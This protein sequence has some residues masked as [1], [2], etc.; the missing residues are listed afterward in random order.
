MATITGAHHVAFTVRDIERSQAWY[1][2]VLGLQ[3]LLDRDD[4]TTRV[5]VMAHPSGWIIGLRQH[6]GQDN[7]GPFSEF[8]TGLD[9]LALTVGSKSELDEW[10]ATLTEHAV[11]F[12]P[13]KETPIGTV[14]AFRD[15]DN[16]ALELWLP[17][18]S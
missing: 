16:I 1:A 14:I 3:L 12:T 8:R 9:H 11:T 2:G 18:G 15:L 4:E 5:R 17:L 6:L 7:G 13:A 10:E